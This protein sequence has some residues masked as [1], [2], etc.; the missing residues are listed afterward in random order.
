[1]IAYQDILLLLPYEIYILHTVK[2]Y[3]R[4][5]L[6]ERAK[7]DKVGLNNIKRKSS[8]ERPGGLQ[9]EFLVVTLI[10]VVEGKH[11][12]LT[13]NN[14]TDLTKALQNLGSIPSSNLIA[15]RVLWTPQQENDTLLGQELLEDYYPL[16][17][18][19]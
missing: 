2:Y 7:F 10:V 9:N 16:L 6:E 8:T 14:N 13:I 11:K 18:P 4:I 17:K 5:E 15:V 12:F 19:F 1:M 3:N